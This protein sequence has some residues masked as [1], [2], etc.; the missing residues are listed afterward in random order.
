MMQI[1]NLTYLVPFFLSPW[2]S[3]EE[4]PMNL[5]PIENYDQQ[6]REE[7]AEW[8]L[9]RIEKFQ[10]ILFRYQQNND[11]NVEDAYQNLS[12]ILRS[13]QTFPRDKR[14]SA[15]QQLLA[16]IKKEMQ[17]FPDHGEH[18]LKPMLEKYKIVRE[19]PDGFTP[20]GA[21]LG[22]IKSAFE[23]DRILVQQTFTTLPTAEVVKAMSELLHDQE[24]IP[25]G[26]GI[27]TPSN[28]SIAI[29]I[30]MKILA[31]PPS[32]VRSPVKEYDIWEEWRDRV[33]AG[34]ETFRLVD[35]PLNLEYSF[36]GPVETNSKTTS[37]T[38]ATSG[39]RHLNNLSSKNPIAQQNAQKSKSSWFLW[40][41]IS[42][43]VALGTGF[44]LF[45]KAESI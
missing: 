19:N 35:D 38:E 41:A 29:D 12:G 32:T 23:R 7:S 30:L 9:R 27:G 44:W 25:Y 37:I 5:W 24:R 17:V 2:L 11:N 16:D 40:F 36:D 28:S 14:L 20:E 18:L 33:Q 21:S 15:E 1:K 45:R 22:P 3:A 39:Q 43:L 6:K 26:D 13:F 8:R 34:K 4:D 31:Q 10:K 42:L